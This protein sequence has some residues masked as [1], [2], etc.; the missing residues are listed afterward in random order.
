MFIYKIKL[1]NKNLEKV[2]SFFNIVAIDE[3]IFF[4]SLQGP[5]TDFEDNIHLHSAA[6]SKCDIYLTNDKKFLS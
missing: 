5:L 4:A 2:F 1:P 3:K 6:I